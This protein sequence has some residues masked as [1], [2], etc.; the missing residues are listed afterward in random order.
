MTEHQHSLPSPA[1]VQ[2][3]LHGLAYP[4]SRDDLINYARNQCEG[5]DHPNASAR[6]QGADDVVLDTIIMIP[7]RSTEILTR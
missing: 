6:D 3:H 5:G 2:H 7:S 4:A 1:L